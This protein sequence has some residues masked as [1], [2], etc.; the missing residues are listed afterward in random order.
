MH[1]DKKFL[2]HITGKNRAT[3]YGVGVGRE[4]F[5]WKGHANIRRKA[6]GRLDPSAEMRARELKKGIRLPRFHERRH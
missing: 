3:R 4:G 1:T 6:N 2:Y 5:T